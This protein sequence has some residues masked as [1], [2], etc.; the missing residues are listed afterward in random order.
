MGS[1]SGELTC[2]NLNKESIV[3]YALSG[4]A[5]ELPAEEKFVVKC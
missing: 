2:T 5:D 4:T 1:Y 3:L